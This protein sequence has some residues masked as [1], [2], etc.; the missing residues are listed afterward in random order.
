V[1]KSAEELEVLLNRVCNDEYL[2]SISIT[3]LLIELSEKFE[4]QFEISKL[5][6]VDWSSKSKIIETWPY[7]KF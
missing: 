7:D 5:S 6:E 2:D 4:T 3:E 1:I